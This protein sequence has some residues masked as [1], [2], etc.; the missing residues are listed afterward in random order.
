[1]SPALLTVLLLIVSNFFMTLAWYG[2]LRLQQMGLIQ[3]W[4]LYAV[5]LASWGVAL[6]EYFLM[7]PA[8][9][10]GFVDNGGPFTLF[11]LKVIQEV[12][13]Y[14]FFRCGPVP[15]S[16]AALPVE[17]SGGIP[18]PCGGGGLRVPSL[19]IVNC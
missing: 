12:L 10:I 14:G 7:I 8:N 11:Q 15:L 2:N 9:R 1:M 6:F 16:G 4:P 3:N 17:S 5:I 13:S 19:Q 18:L